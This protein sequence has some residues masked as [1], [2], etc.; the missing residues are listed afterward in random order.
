MNVLLGKFNNYVAMI[1]NIDYNLPNQDMAKLYGLYKQVHFGNNVYTKP[2]NSLRDMEKWQAWE[3]QRGKS[4]YQSM[5]EYINHV[6]I[7]LTRKKVDEHDQNLNTWNSC[8]FP[9]SFQQE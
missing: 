5:I 7:I 3:N 2:K 6:K 8:I 4:R 9:D 1:N